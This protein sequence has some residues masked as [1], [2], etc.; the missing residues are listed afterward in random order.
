MPDQSFDPKK[1]GFAIIT[2]YPKW[3]RGKLRSI[4]HTDKVR[5]D[6]A[7]EFVKKASGD[8][9][10]MVI[11]DGKSAKTFVRDLQLISGIILLRR[12]TKGSGEGKRAVI[13]KVANIPGVEV[14]VL[15]EPEKITFLTQ[16]L[17]QSVEPILQNKADIVIPKREDSLFKSTYPRYMYDSEVEGNGIYNEALRANNLL[18]KE[19]NDMDT[20]FGPRVFK[21]TKELV[22]LF[23]RKYHFSGFS[24]LEKLYDPDKYS[25][26]QFFPLLNAFKKKLK[27]VSV[28]VPFSYPRLQKENE[29]IGQRELF[30]AKRNLQRVSIL[31]DLMHFLTF[32]QKNKNSRVRILQ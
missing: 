18:P 19:L 26:I 30:I 28:E 6:L 17:Q 11:S 20:F 5:G 29:E 32:L 2:S 16:C 31:I 25:N 4:K 12:K 1:I 10:P 15:V 23:K 3:Y 14:I 13:N 27:V 9:F 22:A 7:L 24:L 21:N 8:G